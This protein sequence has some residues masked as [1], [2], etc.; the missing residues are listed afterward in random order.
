MIKVGD[1]IRLMHPREYSISEKPYAILEVS[2]VYPSGGYFSVFATPGN[3]HGPG[4]WS[5]NHSGKGIHWELFQPAE[6]DGTY[7]YPTVGPMFVG[8]DW[9]NVSHQCVEFKTYV[10]FTDVFDYCA[11]C[12]KRKV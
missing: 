10:G 6:N 3:N 2:H 12:D 8:V 7:T 1:K 4:T 5:I 9:S 11:E